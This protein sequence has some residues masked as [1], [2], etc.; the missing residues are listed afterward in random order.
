MKSPTEQKV[1][2]MVTDYKKHIQL[3]FA[4]IPVGK[5]GLFLAWYRWIF[6]HASK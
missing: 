4:N 5:P 1:D 2:E 6:R 3:M